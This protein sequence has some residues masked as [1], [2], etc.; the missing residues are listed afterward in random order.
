[1]CGVSEHALVCRLN[2]IM[3]TANLLLPCIYLYTPDVIQNLYSVHSNLVEAV[4]VRTFL[5]SINPDL[6][7]LPYARI[8][9]APAED[10]M[11]LVRAFT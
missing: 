8:R 3:G 1:M 4:R 11:T 6:V 5:L 10:Y 2:T 9:Y 7:V